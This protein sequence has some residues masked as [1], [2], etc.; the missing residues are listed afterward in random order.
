MSGRYPDLL[1]RR[2][3]SMMRLAERLL[4]EG[5]YDLAVLNAEYAARL[6]V[7]SVLLRL[8]GEEWKGHGVRTLL[9]AVALTA[10]GGGLRDVAEEIVDF[11]R[12]NRRM[13]AEL[14]EA[15]TRSVYGPFEYSE[16]QARAIL[17]LAKSIIELMKGIEE[18]VFGGGHGDGR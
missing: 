4:S 10:Q 9:G 6:Y 11:T 2:A 8:T 5:E 3:E 13:L 16:E 18:R 12:R 7:K 17:G 14:E 1:K 15:H